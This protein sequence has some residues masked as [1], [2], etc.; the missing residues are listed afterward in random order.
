MGPIPSSFVLLPPSINADTGVVCW[1][2]DTTASEQNSEHS[3]LGAVGH[4]LPW[5]EDK[6]PIRRGFPT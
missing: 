5:Q 1:V 3:S 2:S 4:T 6:Y